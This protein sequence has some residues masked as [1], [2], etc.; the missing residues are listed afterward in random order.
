MNL[1]LPFKKLDVQKKYPQSFPC[2]LPYGSS[3]LSRLMLLTASIKGINYK[4]FICNI[5]LQYTFLAL[6]LV[7]IYWIEIPIIPEAVEQRNLFK[8]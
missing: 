1:L 2:R 8:W 5:Y 4:V 3:A 7:F 6:L